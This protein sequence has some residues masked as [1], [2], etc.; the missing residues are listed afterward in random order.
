[1][2]TP[3]NDSIASLIDDRRMVISMN[4]S[5]VDKA[6]E[7]PTIPVTNQRLKPMFCTL[8]AAKKL[9]DMVGVTIMTVPSRIS[10]N[11]GYWDICGDMPRM[12]TR[13]T[14]ITQRMTAPKA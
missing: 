12:Y 6:T 7:L 13:P 5:M 3:M 1:M 10:M 8:D 14:D 9:K 4:A 11:R 2:T